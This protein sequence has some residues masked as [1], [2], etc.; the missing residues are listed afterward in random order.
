MIRRYC[1]AR[2]VCPRFDFGFKRLFATEA[3]KAL[4]ISFLNAILEGYE[5]IRDITYGRNEHTGMIKDS[6]H[7]VLDIQCDNE[8]GE[9]I[10]VEMQNSTQ[11][12]F[13]DRSIYYTTFPIQEQAIKGKWNFELKGI[14]TIGIINFEFSDMDEDPDTYYSHEVKLL[15]THN[16]KVFYDKLTFFYIELPKFRKTEEELVTM[17]DKWIYVMQNLEQLEERPPVYK[18]PIFDQ[19]FEQAELANLSR[20]EYLQYESNLKHERDSQNI[21]DF[22]MEKAIKQGLDEG[23]KQ[24]LDEGRKQGLDEGRKQGLDEGRKQGLDEGRK[25]G[26]DEGRKQGLD[27]GLK[28]GVE[29]GYQKGYQKGNQLG[30][31]EG[32]QQGILQGVITGKRDMIL[33]LLAHGL[34]LEQIKDYLGLEISEIQKILDQ[35]P[36]A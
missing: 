26:L 21:F 27:E 34:S 15:D 32:K 11:P 25:Q 36:K 9:K 23:R 13:K 1:D 17:L 8:R 14:Y 29:E 6:R 2:Y 24:G 16:H 3:N 31:Q 28:Q 19:L 20:E 18:E 5:V 30:L 10:L 33:C 35:E 12:F 7:G 4:L 22:A